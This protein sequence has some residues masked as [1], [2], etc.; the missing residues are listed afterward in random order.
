M[1][2]MQK[3]LSWLG[4]KIN[5]AVYA[6][7]VNGGQPTW[8][9][10]QKLQQ[11]NDGYRSNDIVYSCINLVSDK[12]KIAP[13]CE[14]TVK[15]EQV[16]RKY[17]SLMERPDLIEDWG[18]MVNMQSK[19]LEMVSVPSKIT[20]LLKYA[21]DKQ[22]FSDFVKAAITY[23]LITGDSYAY[24][25]IIEAGAN[26]G[27]PNSFNALPSQYMSIIANCSEVFKTVVGYQLQ[28]NT[29]TTFAPNE[30][31]HTKSFN[32]NWDGVGSELYGMSPLEAGAR[33]LTR[34][35]E[36]KNYAVAT[37]QNG[38]PVGVMYVKKDQGFQGQDLSAQV[39]LIKERLRQYRGSRNAN[40]IPVSG[41]EIGYQQIGLDP[42]QMAILEAELFDMRAIC[43]LYGVPSQLLND[44]AAKTYNSLIEAEKALTVRGAI[45]NLTSLRDDI[46]LKLYKEWAVGKKRVVDF[47]LSVYP[48]LQ[49]NKKELMDWISKAPISIERTLELLG[50]PVPDWMDEETRRT[51]LMPSNMQALTEMPIDLPNDQ[52]PYAN[53]ND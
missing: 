50:E 32:P 26:K 14:Y 24:T 28:I 2:L 34:S 40:K 7:M 31:V 39:D 16:Y 52:N 25:P 44:T 12:A 20:E 8:S 1:N 48:E 18:A 36:G 49:K 10:Q 4:G 17:K 30:I 27:M 23:K 45:P 46:N 5:N 9:G 21:N 38:G 33:V 11:V 22:T 15:D 47:D 29:V 42:V 43:N 37:M 3:A 53:A 13:W 41:I 51:I 35:N 19:A 6:Q